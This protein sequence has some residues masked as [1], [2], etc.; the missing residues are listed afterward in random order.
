MPKRPKK[1]IA[2][3]PAESP[4]ADFMTVG[5]LVAVLTTL[6]CELLSVA[7]QW[8]ARSS[9]ENATINVFAG[10]VLFAS[11]TT[12]LVTLLL[13][14]IVVWSRRVRPPVG[15]TVFAVVVGAAPL[16]ILLLRSLL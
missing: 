7:A 6:M 14:P 11:V 12:G 9:P 2:A 16:V 13:T 5:W 1:I 3:P 15:I 8:F 10:F 4:A